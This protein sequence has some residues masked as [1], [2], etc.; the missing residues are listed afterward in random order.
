MNCC[1][2]WLLI[3]EDSSKTSVMN[4]SRPYASVRPLT[5]PTAITLPHPAP[6]KKERNM[7][8]I[9]SWLITYTYEV[10]AFTFLTPAPKSLVTCALTLSFHSSC[11]NTNMVGVKNIYTKKKWRRE[12]IWCTHYPLYNALSWQPHVHSS[13][14]S[15]LHTAAA[16]SRM[17]VGWV[18]AAHQLW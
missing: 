17:S 3:F 13:H 4:R 6:R 1:S 8:T 11:V 2:R 14:Q 18:W 16:H 15:Q 12:L 9:C 5:I 7:W 10:C